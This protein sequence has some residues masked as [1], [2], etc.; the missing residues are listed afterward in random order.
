MLPGTSPLKIVEGSIRIKQWAF[1]TQDGEIYPLTAAGNGAEIVIYD[2]LDS[3]N[4]YGTFP[5]LANEMAGTLTLLLTEL[6]TQAL[7]D[8][9]TTAIYYIEGLNSDNE[10]QMLLHGTVAIIR[11]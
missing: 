3:N 11:K 6:E 5:V 10:K 2:K 4:I 7:A 1:E 9:F 8:L